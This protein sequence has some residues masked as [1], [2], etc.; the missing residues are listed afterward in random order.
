MRKLPPAVAWVEFLHNAST[1]ENSYSFPFSWGEA[2]QRV[3]E[4]GAVYLGNY[5]QVLIACGA[6]VMYKRPRALAGLALALA[7]HQAGK[8]LAPIERSHARLHAVLSLLLQI[9]VWMI[10]SFS[11]ATAVV[12]YAVLVGLSGACGPRGD[13]DRARSPS[14]SVADD[15]DDRSREHLPRSAACCLH[16][17]LRTPRSILRSLKLDSPAKSPSASP[18]S[19]KKDTGKRR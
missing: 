11:T 18:L 14:G 19:A 17:L 6:G 13:G 4:N 1:L 16:A 12:A 2:L 10:L 3:N 8:R 9:V 7:L 5:V 15:D